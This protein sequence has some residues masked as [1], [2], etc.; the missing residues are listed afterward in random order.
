MLNHP[1]PSQK[2]IRWVK[3]EKHECVK[4]NVEQTTL[5]MGSPYK[6]EGIDEDTGPSA[7][8][9]ISE[10]GTMLSQ[11]MTMAGY[12]TE[13]RR[14][15]RRFFNRF[16][17]PALGPHP[18]TTSGRCLW[19]S[20]MTDEFTPVELS[21]SWSSKAA[22]P[23]VRYSF[24]A[25]KEYA[26][27]QI[28][29]SN[30]SF[31][32]NAAFNLQGGQSGFDISWLSFFTQELYDNTP[33]ILKRQ[34]L[35]SETK[36]SLMFF[37][38]DLLGSDKMAKLYFILNCH[39]TL[40]QR[41]NLGSLQRAF[42]TLAP[43]D[44]KLQAAVAD[45]SQL[46]LSTYRRA[47]LQVEIVAFDCVDPHRGR[48][49]IYVRD[50]RTSF[51]SVIDMMTLGGILGPMSRS[52]YLA[53]ARLWQQ[54]LGLGP[55]FSATEA[56]PEVDHRTAGILYYFEFRLDQSVPRPKLY[57]PVRHY[58][59]NDRVVAEGL[60]SYLQSRNKR[61]IGGDYLSCVQELW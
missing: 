28:D 23:S 50:K 15:H 29:P 39:D 30:P 48:I 53:L 55:N 36:S 59:A 9:W 57:I 47:S 40:S 41:L 17:T 37:A 60:S 19:N 11:M 61:L 46:L 1:A 22:L 31:I 49:K 38:L 14:T 5:L 10:I 20:F 16:V 3:F 8:Y 34:R 27:M 21:W 35:H 26:G 33:N 58:A 56:L 44:M 45:F 7:A 18:K 24:E 13:S 51:E 2:I 6:I 52:S 25:Y 12:D 43:Q 32:H 4:A 42:V 54:V